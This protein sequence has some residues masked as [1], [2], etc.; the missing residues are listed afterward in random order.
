MDGKN[1]KKA[2]ELA[3]L[4]WT[5]YIFEDQLTTGGPVYV[6]QVAFLPGCMAQGVTRDEAISDLEVAKVSYIESML[7]DGL[8]VPRPT[9][10]HSDS[11]SVGPNS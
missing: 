5:Y 4:A 11:V 9:E 6:A 2:E 10:T 3:Q 8:P 7:D 1:R